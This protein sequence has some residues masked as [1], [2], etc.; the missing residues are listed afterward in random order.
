MEENPQQAFL[1][2][3]KDTLGVTWDELAEASGISPR[4]L[5]TYR[6]PETSQDHRAL[7]NLARAAIAR[8]LEEKPRSRARRA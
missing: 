2:R 7:P 4:A 6:M 3:A 5:K 8:L 1:R